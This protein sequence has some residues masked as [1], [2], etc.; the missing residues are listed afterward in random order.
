[1]EPRTI[2]KQELA[3]L[4]CPESCSSSARVWLWRQIRETRGLLEALMAVGY[5]PEQKKKHFSCEECSVIIRYL[6]EP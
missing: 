5:D 1:M 2:T 3:Q 6:G 4:Y